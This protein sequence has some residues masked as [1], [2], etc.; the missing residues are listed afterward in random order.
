M[1]PPGVRGELLHL[2]SGPRPG[3]APVTLLCVDR[4]Q[5]VETGVHKARLQDRFRSCRSCASHLW[6][7]GEWWEGV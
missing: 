4:A 6:G 5:P 7:R 2:P 3:P 1:V